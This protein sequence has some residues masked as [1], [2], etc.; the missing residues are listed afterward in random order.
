M[1]AGGT[2]HP[3]KNHTN[4]GFLS[5][6]GPDPL[7]ITKRARQQNAIFIGTPWKCFAGGPMMARLIIM[8]LFS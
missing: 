2:V 5:S 3:L 8:A 7:K 4:I 1:G 6:T